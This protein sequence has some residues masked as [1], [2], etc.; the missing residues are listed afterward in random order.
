MTIGPQVRIVSLEKFPDL[1]SSAALSCLPET[2]TSVQQIF[3][4]LN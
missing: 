3:K 1:V 2:M 4:T